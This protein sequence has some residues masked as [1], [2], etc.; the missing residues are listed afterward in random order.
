[1]DPIS[2]VDLWFTE[3]TFKKNTN[4]EVIHGRPVKPESR[5]EVIFHIKVL[6]IKI[7]GGFHGIR[8]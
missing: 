2:V 4:Y 1:M 7:L 6:F 5:F 8:D 3:C